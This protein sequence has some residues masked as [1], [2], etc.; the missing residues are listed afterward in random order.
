[1]IGLRLVV[2][3]QC[4]LLIA[5]KSL[6]SELSFAAK[7]SSAIFLLSSDAFF[8]GFLLGFGHILIE[9]F[10]FLTRLSP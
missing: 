9:M 2:L 7:I 5:D 3:C 1:M 10:T 6:P 4:D 8:A